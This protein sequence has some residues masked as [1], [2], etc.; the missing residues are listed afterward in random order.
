MNTC[1]N[2]LKVGD[3]PVCSD[4]L[5]VGSIDADSSSIF[6]KFESIAT[7]RIVILPAISDGEG[8]VTIDLSDYQFPI[9]QSMYLSLILNQGDIS[10]PVEITIEE[11]TTNELLV[12]FISCVD[13]DNDEVNVTTSQLY[14]V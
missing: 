14:L 9:N 11:Q 4:S 10:N 12:S 2:Y 13:G 1:R 7:G 8:V 5:I 3:V 6:A